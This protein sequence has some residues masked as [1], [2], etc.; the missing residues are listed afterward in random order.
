MNYVW[1]DQYHIEERA[2]QSK[3][4]P[5]VNG[6][7]ASL[8]GDTIVQFFAPNNQTTIITLR[9]GLWLS[10]AIFTN[11]PFWA[12]MTLG[13]KVFGTA[14]AITE[15]AFSICAHGRFSAIFQNHKST[16]PLE[17]YRDTAA[18]NYLE[19]LHKP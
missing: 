14:V 19:P 16:L 9:N 5:F 15:A 1:S 7:S 18:G 2:V 6:K 13:F 17:R 12:C 3:G 10:T 8:S 11:L 4:A